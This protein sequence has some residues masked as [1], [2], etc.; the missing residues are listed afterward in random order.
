MSSQGVPTAGREWSMSERDLPPRA[1][2]S[3]AAWARRNLFSSW[4]NSVL[5]AAM[6]VVVAW[7]VWRTVK[8]VFVTAEWEIVQ[9]NLTLFMVGRFPRDELWRMWVSIGILAATLG[10]VGGMLAATAREV[11]LQLGRPPARRGLLPLVRRFWPSIALVVV[12]L[13]FTRTL[14]PTLLTAVVLAVGTAAFHLGRVAPASVRGRWWLVFLGG[15]AGSVVVLVAA[16]GIGW[17]QW[18]GLHLNLFVAFAGIVFAFPLGLLLALGRRSSLPAVRY[19]S[20]AYIELFRGVPLITLL[21]VAQLALGFFLPTYLDPPGL[22]IRALIVI[23][24]FESAY[25]AEIVRGGLQ[26]IPRG[27]IEAGQALGLSPAAIVRRVTLPQAL[28]SVIPATV[29]QF[30]SLFQDTSLLSTI[31]L[32]EVLAVSQLVTSQS[33]FVGRG[34]ASVTLPFVAFIFWAVS[35]SMSKE[36]RRLEARLGIGVR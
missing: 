6:A 25:I 29:G 34:L 28:R 5:T 13:G 16:G 36:S 24:I 2:N 26:A 8:F 17:N 30:I 35:Y 18:S 20:I 9:R 11:A 31:T 33:D 23:V 21:L 3:P 32:T 7:V 10:V 19:V 15:L 14:T 27:Q 12:L 22:V 4:F 1:D